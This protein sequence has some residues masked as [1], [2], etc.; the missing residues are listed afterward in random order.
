MN[1]MQ[2]RVLSF[3]RRGGPITTGVLAN[4]MKCSNQEVSSIL[5]ELKSQGLIVEVVTD[6]IY[7]GESVIKWE[8][9]K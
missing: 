2:K 4:K 9:A 3:V 8:S 6:K 7:N 1:V 5:N